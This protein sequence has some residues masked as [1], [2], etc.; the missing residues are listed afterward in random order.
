MSMLL[1][2][3]GLHRR[4]LEAVNAGDVDGVLALFVE[5]A[6][7]WDAFGC[8]PN[9]QGTAR[10]RQALE[11]AVTN[12]WR[13]DAVEIQPMR[14][15]F[16]T[17]TV[18]R[19][20]LRGDDIAAAGAER[21]RAGFAL[22]ARDGKVAS[23]RG[24]YD[25]ADEQTRAFR[26][27]PASPSAS[28]PRPELT[29]R[30]EGRFVEV[31]GRRMYMECMGEGT[32][33]VV[34]EGGA[35]SGLAA[36]GGVWRGWP[37][38]PHIAIQQDIAKTT[39]VCAYDRASYGLSD[40]RPRPSDGRQDAQDL[41]RLLHAAG[42]A[43]PYVVGGISSGGPTVQIFAALYPDE[44]AGIVFMD[45]SLDLDYW[46]RLAETVP[47]DIAARMWENLRTGW[48]R[49]RSPQG[50]GGGLDGEATLHQQHD[51]RSLPDVP[52]V[53]LV[54]GVPIGPWNM[55]GPA[56]D[57]EK[58]EQ[59][60]YEYHAALARLSPRGQMRIVDTS[61]HAMNI[62]APDIIAEAVVEVVRAARR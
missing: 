29:P 48:E 18:S 5:N 60:R 3:E 45:S 39:R 2:G 9:C 14:T 34:L 42:I 11:A 7:V 17:W 36:S 33:T 15:S 55:P 38:N 53:A 47:S 35:G 8:T 1:G 12:R 51:A 31:D 16:T 44:V 6:N 59:L 27:R 41:H 50:P 62:F 58:R 61:E 20:D 23:L 4:L 43:P 30:P 49:E 22:A 40:P 32:P 46:E 25:A 56:W 37:A 28:Q 13:F 10:I 54:A 57:A 52:L 21:I 19:T 26:T 24:G